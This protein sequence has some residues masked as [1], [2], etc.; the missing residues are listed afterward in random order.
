MRIICLVIF[1]W[2]SGS[3]FSQEKHWKQEHFYK[4]KAIDAWDVDPMGKLILAERDV[5]VKL[6][7]SFKVQFTQSTKQLGEVAILDAAH[8]LKTLVFSELQQ[9]VSFVD[10]TLTFQ[11]GNKDLSSYNVAYATNVGYSNQTN[12]FWVYD[13]DN[14]QILLIDETGNQISTIN[15]LSSITGA[16]Q[17]KDL[18]ERDNELMLFYEGVGTFFFDYYGS[19]ISNFPMEEASA[20]HFNK[21]HIYFILDN[22]VI[23][24]DRKTEQREEFEMPDQEILGIRV[25][26]NAI[27]LEVPEGIKKYSLIPN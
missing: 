20:V 1:V 19:L 7:T 21:D 25:H 5:L 2:V 22:K 16:V 17:P 14:A 8:S 26:G 9:Y 11:E 4:S 10:N 12:R 27:F 15:N 6:D 18:F 23:K 3:L 24:V 13:G